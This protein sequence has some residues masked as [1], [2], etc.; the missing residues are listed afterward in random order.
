MAKEVTM[1][2]KYGALLY[3]VL[4]LTAALIPPVISAI[5]LLSGK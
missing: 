1:R 3:D 5:E 4:I 2:E